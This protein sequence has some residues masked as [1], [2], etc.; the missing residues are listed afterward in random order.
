[1]RRLHLFTTA[2][3]ATAAI[4]SPA[5]A[6][7][8]VVY[9][10]TA[11]A[12]AA[13]KAHQ[14]P[15]VH[16]S[17]AENNNGVVTLGIDPSGGAA[18]AG[19]SSPGATTVHASAYQPGGAGELIFDS[20]AYAA[21]SLASGQLKATVDNT[22]ANNFGSPFGFADASISD[23]LYFTNT[24][25]HAIALDIS[26]AFDGMIALGPNVTDQGGRATL[27]LSG[28][29]S[30]GDI[31]FANGAGLFSNTMSF[32]EGGVY[33]YDSAPQWTFVANPTGVGGTLS[34]TLLVGTG[35]TSLG[36]GGRLELDCRGGTDCLFGHTASLGL[37]PLADG[38]S[39][40]SESGVFLTDTGG[41]TGG[42]PEPGVWA[43]MILGFGGAGTMVRR[44]R[45]ALA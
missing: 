20:S 41:P 42:V 12:Y 2:I 24:T 32:N 36:I 30:C 27:Y 26:Y 19:P 18:E 22:Y 37:G 28:C 44:R 35:L 29:G 17:S 45:A 7:H 43:L 4:S 8:T 5:W 40:A 33:A 6:D 39:Y 11:K 13:A 10:A 25:D 14:G 1:M 16:G 3:A 34:A 31:S 9:G 21:A 15:T 38:L 23:T